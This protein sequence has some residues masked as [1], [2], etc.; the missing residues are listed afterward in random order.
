[1]GYYNRAL[2]HR[3][4]RFAAI[5]ERIGYGN[6]QMVTNETNEV[7]EPEEDLTALRVEYQDVIGKKPYHG[8]D[9]ETLREKIREASLA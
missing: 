1:M 5:L 8:W 4:G 7:Y 9:A 2:K 3:D 6:R